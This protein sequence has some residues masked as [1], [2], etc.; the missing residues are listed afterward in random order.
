MFYIIKEGSI[1]MNQSH[2]ALRGH[3]STALKVHHG[4]DPRSWS[5]ESPYVSSVFPSQ[6]VY[7][8]KGQTYRNSYSVEQGGAGTDPKISLG[9]TPK[10]VHAAYTDSATEAK[11]A[12]HYLLD[13]E[14]IAAP[15]VIITSDGVE[16]VR[17][18]IVF[19]E[20]VRVEESKGTTKVPVKL[21]A[22]GWGS[23]AY[24]SKEVLKRDGPKVFAKGTHMMW[25]HQ[26]DTEE[27][28]R[29]EG[30]LN[31]L[32]A[33]LTKDAEWLDNGPKGPGLYSEA[34]VFSDYANQVTEKGAHIG[35]SINAGIKAHEG[36]AEG[37]QGRIADAFVRAFS[38]DFVTKAGAGGAPV[39]PVI[40]SDRARQEGVPTMDEKDTAT[41]TALEADKTRLTTEN[42]SL[43][44]RLAKVE[45]DGFVTAAI[46][47]VTAKLTEADIPFRSKVVDRACQ[48]PEVKEGKLDPEWLKTIVADFTEGHTAKVTGMGSK[49][50]DKSDQ[51][52]IQEAEKRLGAALGNL[53][54]P[55]QGVKV[56]VAG[57]A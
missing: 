22:P 54:L 52:S 53:G 6:V 12:K 40:E 41:M 48:H 31:D 23:M 45:Q 14:A 26:T 56:A 24:Y 27:A 10:L 51:T 8:Y 44:E 5:E 21:I 55:E 29:P 36:Q 38:T 39:V 30:D 37:R 4:V 15:S 42:S 7:S 1:P 43:K 20:T 35:V 50:S 49:E 18:S 11:V 9:K 57:R 19:D 34:K 33:V 2:D 25:N 46:A 16:Q 17:E 3:I 13:H 28:E 32:A 47:H